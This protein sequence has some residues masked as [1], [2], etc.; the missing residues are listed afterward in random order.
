M[1][2]EIFGHKKGAFT[3]AVANRPGAAKLAHGGSLFLD[4]TCELEPSLQVNLF[5]FA[6]TSKIRK[7][8]G[9]RAKSSTCG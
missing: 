8:G 5:R 4:E 1:E 2:S 6:Q 9:D 3:G 7:V